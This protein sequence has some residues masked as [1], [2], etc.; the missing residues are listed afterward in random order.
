MPLHVRPDRF[1]TQNRR[2]ESRPQKTNADAGTAALGS[3]DKTNR[4]LASYVC[5]LLASSF[6]RIGRP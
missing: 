5:P 6:S 3:A 4:C 2:V 1:P